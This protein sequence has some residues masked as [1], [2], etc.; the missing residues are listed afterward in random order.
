MEEVSQPEVVYIPA[1]HH[2]LSGGFS[3]LGKRMLSTLRRASRGNGGGGARGRRGRGGQAAHPRLDIDGGLSQ[4]I[5]DE[6]ADE[7][8]LI[9]AED[10]VRLPHPASLFPTLPTW[11]HLVAPLFLSNVYA[12]EPGSQ[13]SCTPLVERGSSAP[14]CRVTSKPTLTGANARQGARQPRW[15]HSQG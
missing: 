10:N 13:S 4:R 11:F 14:N 1:G 6:M 7:A 12:R 15:L 8:L 2:E 5:L 3:K 9:R